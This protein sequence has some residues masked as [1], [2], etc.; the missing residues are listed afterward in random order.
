MGSSLAV[1]TF[2]LRVP[3]PPREQSQQGPKG[4]APNG[5]SGAPGVPGPP[6]PVVPAGRALKRDLAAAE[7]EPWPDASGDRRLNSAPAAPLLKETEPP[8]AAGVGPAGRDPAA[9]GALAGRVSQGGRR[10]LSPSRH[11]AQVCA[12]GVGSIPVTVPGAVWDP[13]SVQG[14]T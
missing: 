13:G 6:G 1:P 9:R 14:H 11:P 10:I 7:A 12:V 3:S 5:A 2:W 4:P 8:G